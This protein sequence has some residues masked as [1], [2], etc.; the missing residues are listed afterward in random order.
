MTLKLNPSAIEKNG[1]PRQLLFLTPLPKTL[2]Q[3]SMPYFLNSLTFFYEKLSY[4]LTT[5]NLKV[6]NNP[7]E[8]AK[9]TTSHQLQK[10]NKKNT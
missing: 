8:S 5:Q 6:I 10:K 7:D 1:K 3:Y 2:Y 4:I 9:H